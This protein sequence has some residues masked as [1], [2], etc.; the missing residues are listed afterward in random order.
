MA[1]RLDFTFNFTQPQHSERTRPHQDQALRIL[2]LGDFTGR[3]NR[4]VM[5]AGDVAARPLVAVDVDNFDDVMFRFAPQLNLPL[6]ERAVASE[7]V[8]FKCLDDFHPDALFERLSVFDALRATRARL[9]DTAHFAQAAAELRLAAHEHAAAQPVR[10]E[11]KAAMF[12]RLLGRGPVTAAEMRVP[13]PSPQID[14]QGLIRD[15][16]APYIVPD[17]DPRQAQ[18]L[19]AVELAISDHMRGVLHHPAFQA[20]EARWRGLHWLVSRLETDETLQVSLLDVTRSELSADIDNAERAEDAGICRLLL[21]KGGGTLGGAPWSLMVGLYTFDHTADD[22]ELLAAL[23]A[24]AAQAGA[25]FIGAAAP[26]VVGC[27]SFVDA[28]HPRNWTHEDNDAAQRWH[29]LRASAVA[30]WIGLALPRFLLRLPYGPRTDDIEAFAFEEM[31]PQRPHE[32]YLWGNPALACAFLIG[33]A[34][35]RQGW[36][37][38]PGDVLEV[39]D[40]PAHIYEEDG[41]STMQPCGEVLLSETAAE[42]VLALGVMPLVSY[43]ARNAVRVLRFQ[44]LA[45]PPTSL[46]GAWQ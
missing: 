10:D 27:R 13:A 31:P 14:I 19:A 17:P 41:E 46:A 16:V 40:L 38:S 29:A 6:G 3:E 30:P 22:A 33:L 39:D 32:A 1:G 2:V 21:E 24:L 20:L 25:P 23:G 12:E 4:G 37:M 44:S 28:P 43:R 35:T 45:D 18:Y 11:D 42:A 8:E 7:S 36:A 15:I 9:Q 34:F 5:Q 26:A